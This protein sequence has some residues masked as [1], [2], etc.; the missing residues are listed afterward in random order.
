MAWRA[1]GEA[2]C[3]LT[4]FPTASHTYCHRQALSAQHPTKQV[5][6]D[7]VFRN[8]RISSD[9]LGRWYSYEIYHL[10]YLPGAATPECVP[11]S[12]DHVFKR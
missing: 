6:E 2:N 10:S 9:Y 7:R 11:A 3:R 8:G 12:I 5:G 1:R 4:Q